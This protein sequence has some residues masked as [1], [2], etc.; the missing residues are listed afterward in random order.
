MPLIPKSGKGMM[1]SAYVSSVGGFGLP[2][3]EAQLATVNAFRALP[4]N[5][6]YKCAKYGAPQALCV[7]AKLEVNPSLSI[8]AETH[9]LFLNINRCR[10]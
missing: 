10:M 6:E 7:L 2:L 3:T 8:T 1:I 4:A 9:A 5:K